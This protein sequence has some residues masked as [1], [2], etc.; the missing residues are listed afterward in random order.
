MSCTA[1]APAA[2]GGHRSPMTWPLLVCA[3]VAV[4]ALVRLAATRNDLWL[5]EIWTLELLGMI[6]SPLAIL[7]VLH[8]DNNHVV[9]SFF[10]YLLRPLGSDWVLR[11]PAWAAGV[12]VVGLGA[13][14]AALDDEESRLPS[15]RSADASPWRR[16]FVAAVVLGGSHFLVHYGSEARGYSFAVA[17]GLLSTAIAFRDGLRRRSARAPVFWVALVLAVLGH[18]L[19]IHVVAGLVAW[20][21]WRIARRRPGWGEAAG[22]FAWWFGVPAL[23]I[24][25]FYL[26]FVRGMLV[27][28]GP[29]WGAAVALR[30]AIAL[31]TGLPRMDLVVLLP[32]AVTVLLAGVVLLRALGSDVWVFYLV[33]IAVS[34]ALLQ[35]AQPTDLFYPR[36][37]VVSA[38]L[39]L[40]LAA[41]LL[42]WLANRGG[43]ARAAALVVLVAFLASNGMRIADLLRYGRGAY[44][45]TL[46]S[47]VLMTPKP[48]VT[49]AGDADTWNTS[50]IRHHASRLG[51][52]QQIRYLSQ[53]AL[54]NEG[55]D[56]YL[57]NGGGTTADVAPS[58]TD[59]HGN[60]YR[61]TLRS[62]GA[63]PA[64][65][66]WCAYRRDPTAT[67]GKP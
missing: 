22:T 65:W 38:A 29:R 10:V 1:D 48:I 5:D 47:M 28:G 32:V 6:H 61:L 2:R 55:A 39:W 66:E 13:W 63:W 25:A 49:V 44:S 3:T 42:A 26:G 33:S 24:G 64:S 56:W 20:A 58:V 31:T 53:V 54:G 17:F 16:A 45:E 9:N 34:P 59:G 4:G 11:L 23:A 12:A 52:S 15:E 27:G 37:F 46:R 51:L 60:R 50:L 7:T 14:L 43:V 36:Y 35:L 40:I 57:T 30:D 19:A 62:R 8:H 18:L 67:A 41:R 21:M